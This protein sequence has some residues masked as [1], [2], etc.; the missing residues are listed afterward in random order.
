[1]LRNSNRNALTNYYGE[2]MSDFFLYRTKET[3]TLEVSINDGTLRFP[4]NDETLLMFADD[5]PHRSDGKEY[6]S[7][8]VG[9][10]KWALKRYKDVTSS[11]GPRQ[12]WK[13]M[14]HTFPTHGRKGSLPVWHGR[15]NYE[16]L[17][18]WVLEG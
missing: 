1:M 13:V 3:I 18:S 9:P 16:E 7:I 11:D 8:M 2:G 17:S 15:F 10:N 5:Q 6:A 4:L 12:N 14:F